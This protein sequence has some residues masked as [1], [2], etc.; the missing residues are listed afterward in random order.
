LYV[1]DAGAAAQESVVVDVMPYFSASCHSGFHDGPDGFY[2]VYRNLF[3]ELWQQEAEAAREQNMKEPRWTSFGKATSTDYA[4]L[5]D[6]YAFWT[7]FASVMTFEWQDMYYAPDAVNRRHRRAVEKE[8]KKHRD[9]ARRSFNENV[10]DLAK[11]VKRRDQRFQ[12][13]HEEAKAAQE[14]RELLAKSQ[15]RQKILDEQGT[16]T[17]QAQSWQEVS[18]EALMASLDGRLHQDAAKMTEEDI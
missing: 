8:N 13:L 18:E 6:F 3:E 17:F 7:N 10:R 14:T 15:R 9:A 1:G 4:G 12:K 2:A 5:K 16:T 11:Y